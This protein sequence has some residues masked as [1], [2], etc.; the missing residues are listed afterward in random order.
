[1]ANKKIIIVIFVIAGLLFLL[2]QRQIESEQEVD[3]IFYDENGKVIRNPETQATVDIGGAVFNN[4]A[5]FDVVVRGI[6]LGTIPPQALDLELTSFSV[7][8]TGNWG[9]N[10]IFNNIPDVSLR[11]VA[12]STAPNNFVTWS[13]VDSSRGSGMFSI[14]SGSGAP[15]KETEGFVGNTMSFAV[16]VTGYLVGTNDFIDD[17]I[18]T[19]DVTFTQ[20]VTGAVSAEIEIP[21]I[22]S[23]QQFVSMRTTNLNYK[24]GGIAFAEVCGDQLITAEWQLET[25]SSSNGCGLIPGTIILSGLP[26]LLVDGVDPNAPI[27]L[28]KVDSIEY[29][30]C[31]KKLGGGLMLEVFRTDIA[32]TVSTST[33]RSVTQPERD[34]EVTC[35]I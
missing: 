30:I 12:Q 28:I 2:Q 10:I 14:E 18:A 29:R 3:F 13:T 34:R 35:I 24:S 16:V 1:M 22:L 31:Q 4:V 6:N 11:K 33:T 19:L 15:V 20:D 7:S 23:G 32:T 25:T 5:S 8:P 21:G 17:A 9:A 26:G 27:E